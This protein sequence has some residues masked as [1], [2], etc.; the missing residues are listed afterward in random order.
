MHYVYNWFLLHFCLE[1]LCLGWA[2]CS[3]RHCPVNTVL[4]SVVKFKKKWLFKCTH[5]LPISELLTASVTSTADDSGWGK[6]CFASCKTW[7][8][9]VLGPPTWFCRY[10]NTAQT[11]NL[12]VLFGLYLFNQHIP[13]KHICLVFMCHLYVFFLKHGGEMRGWRRCPLVWQC[14]CS[15]TTICYNTS[16]SSVTQCQLQP[17]LPVLLPR[18]WCPLFWQVLKHATFISH[19]VDD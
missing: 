13:K 11:F 6:S 12:W 10:S 3:Y 19:T 2:F 9:Y 14:A 4:F 1:L 16:T 15:T 8:D 17:P 7:L 5:L 18:W